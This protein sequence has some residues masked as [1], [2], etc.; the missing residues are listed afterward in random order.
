MFDFEAGEVLLID[1]PS[2]WTSFDVVAKLRSITRCK[3]IGHA[4]TLDPLAT[5]LLICCT[6]HKTK[7]IAAIQDAPKEYEATMKLGAT[8]VTYDAEAPEEHVVDASHISQAQLLAAMQQFT[9]TITQTPPAYSAIKVGGQRSYDLARKGQA[10]ELKAR[11]VQITAFDLLDYQAPLAQLRIACSK[12]TYIR[13]LVHDLGQVLGV[14]AYLAGLR[15]TRIGH[16]SLDDALTLERLAAI[17][18]A[19]RTNNA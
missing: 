13:S 10:V 11:T 14:G 16:Y 4:G 1:K 12:G 19:A 8:T 6:G 9:G 2:G 17:V 3:K 15:R 7:G 5:G 18:T